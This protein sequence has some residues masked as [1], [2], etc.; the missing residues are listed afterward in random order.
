VALAP[1]SGVLAS[2]SVRV[3]DMGNLDEAS[4]KRVSSRI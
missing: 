4:K 3:C 2:S 1:E